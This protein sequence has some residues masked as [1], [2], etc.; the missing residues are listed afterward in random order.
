MPR[1]L[2]Y[3]LNNITFFNDGQHVLESPDVLANIRVRSYPKLNRP[4]VMQGAEIG[5]R[6]VIPPGSVLIEKAG[7][8]LLINLE[9]PPGP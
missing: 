8:M 2:N 3:T 7:C 5:T 6:K 1:I 4:R 9:Q